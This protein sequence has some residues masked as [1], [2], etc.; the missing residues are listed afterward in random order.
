[1]GGWKYTPVKKI[2]GPDTD[3][4]MTPRNMLVVKIKDQG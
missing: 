1:M 3:I 2:A 4:Q